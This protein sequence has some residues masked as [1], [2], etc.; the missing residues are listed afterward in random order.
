M[1]DLGTPQSPASQPAPDYKPAA[2]AGNRLLPAL[3]RPARPRSVIWPP[4]AGT[5]GGAAVTGLLTPGASFFAWYSTGLL[6][7]MALFLVI[8]G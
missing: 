7:G 4:R 8:L 2:G 1:T 5:I 6:A 3:V